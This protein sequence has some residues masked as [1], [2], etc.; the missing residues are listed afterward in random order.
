MTTAAEDRN[1]RVLW[2][3]LEPIHAVTYFSEDAV[4]AFASAGLPGFWR[5]Y[6]AGRAAPLSDAS[7]AGV[8]AAFYGFAPATVSRAIPDVWTRCD[9]H[10]AIDAR[11]AGAAAALRRHVEGSETLI[12]DIRRATDL[13]RTAVSAVAKDL[14]APLGAA[15][16]ALSIPIDPLE[17]LWHVSTVLREHRGD[18]HVAALRNAELGPCSATTLRCLAAGT[19]IAVVSSVR[20]WAEE[21]WSD[22]RRELAKRGLV[23]DS[24]TSGDL[25][26]TKDGS[27]LLSSV[28]HSTDRASATLLRAAAT[29]VQAVIALLRPLALRLADSGAVPYPNA[30]GVP[31]VREADASPM[32][33]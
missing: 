15:N 17:A 28:E 22:A 16:A 14:D 5:G 27:A 3:I 24:V 25:G 26:I 11:L 21:D 7:A 20:G 32:P 31:D 29:D 2:T 19:D 30:I 23:D 10:G 1:S 8:T 18:A 6:F 4:A 9:P 13:L 33:N 12:G